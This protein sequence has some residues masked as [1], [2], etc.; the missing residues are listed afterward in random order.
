MRCNEEG[1]VGFLKNRERMNVAVTR[2]KEWL[3]IF[4]NR[5][6]LQNVMRLLFILT[7][8]LDNNSGGYLELLLEVLRSMNL[9]D[10]KRMK[11][12]SFA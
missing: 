6:T 8:L 10:Y 4:G 1:T 7:K 5:K 12:S 9:R 2:A 11:I 3:L